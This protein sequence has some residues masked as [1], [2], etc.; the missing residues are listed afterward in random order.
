MNKKK[1]PCPECNKNMV[2]ETYNYCTTC[3]RKNHKK[4]EVCKECG[5]FGVTVGG[6][7]LSCYNARHNKYKNEEGKRYYT[8]RERALRLKGHRCENPNCPMSNIG[9]PTK[10]LDVHHIDGNRENNRLENLEVLCVWC[11]AMK[12][13]DIQI[14]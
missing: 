4:K 10:M 1:K 6:L 5:T 3:Y 2:D 8:Y 12:T 11:H 14:L 9:I 13:R 7:C